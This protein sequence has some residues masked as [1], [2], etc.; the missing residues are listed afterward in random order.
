M[1]RAD[2]VPAC[3]VESKSAAVDHRIGGRKL[4]Y[5]LIALW[6]LC[7]SVASAATQVSIS[8][9]VPSVSIGINVPAYP[10]FVRVPNYP[11]YYAPRLSMNVFFYDGLYWVYQGNRWY[12]SSWYNGPWGMVAPQGVPLFILRVPVRYYRQPPVYFSGWAVDAPPRWG[13]HWGREW[14]QSRSGWDRWNRSSAP[15]PAPLPVY[16]RQYSGDRYPQADLQL[17][18][19]SQ[20]YTYQ[21]REA[22]IQQYYKEQVVPKSRAPGQQKK[23][24]SQSAKEYAPGQVK[25]QQG[26]QS[27]KEHA[28]GQVKQQQGAQS[29]KEYAPGQ[30]GKEQHDQ[31]A[32]SKPN[33]D[34]GEGKGKGG[35]KD[36]G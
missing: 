10:E 25:T 31:G 12:A 23:Q 30:Q 6:M 11:V 26:A 3:A 27:A 19:H 4:R 33:K 35:G 20:K 14:E 13:E 21:P 28:P 1:R 5:G 7:C 18:L 9:G 16:Q 2:G 34:Q 22:V 17:E 24:G 32:G 8:I 36:K 29:A 15:A